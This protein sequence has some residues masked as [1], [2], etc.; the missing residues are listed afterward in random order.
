MLFIHS[1]S[2]SCQRMLFS[3]QEPS[4]WC[5]QIRV[6][7]GCI[8]EGKLLSRHFHH[9]ESR[10]RQQRLIWKKLQSK[11]TNS[12]R[13]E[14]GQ[15]AW[16]SMIMPQKGSGTQEK[17]QYTCKW[18]GALASALHRGF[19]CKSREERA[20]S[21]DLME[22][23]VLASDNSSGVI[24]IETSGNRKGK[25]RFILTSVV[26]TYS[27]PLYEIHLGIISSIEKHR[28][29]QEMPLTGWRGQ[30]GARADSCGVCIKYRLSLP[31]ALCD[32]RKRTMKR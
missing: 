16:E 32:L 22:I 17:R 21:S 1:F 11:C 28:G 13:R 12:W 5:S 25:V 10:Q 27:D 19:P 9:D 26:E 7:H 29:N 4:T 3:S 30:G 23:G 14:K 20:N 31:L 8:D 24:L 15:L 18:F 2:N 6:Q